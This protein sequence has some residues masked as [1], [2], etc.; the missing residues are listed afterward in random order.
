MRSPSSSARDGC[1]RVATVAPGA[2]GRRILAP[3]ISER[4]Q[5]PQNPEERGLHGAGLLGKNQR[6]SRTTSVRRPRAEWIE[7]PVPAI[8]DQATFD[9]A[10]HRLR[11][12]QELSSRHCKHTYLLSGYLNCG[13]CG[14]RMTGT[15][16]KGGRRYHC[17]S[18][19]NTHD[20]NA[21]CR[22]SVAAGALERQVW[23]AVNR[24][25]QDPELIA[26]EVARQDAHAE[27]QR[28]GIHQ[29]L[30]AIDAALMKCEKEAQRWAEGLRGRGD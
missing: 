29:E 9:A 15:A 12:N 3:G 13:R 5:H 22:G 23:D 2:G 1:R 30:A 14:R 17:S 26:A 28:Q 4:R 27:E 7:I 8:I 19:H 18:V 6:T 10:Q 20:P 25:L 11:R 21:Q 16:P 24:V